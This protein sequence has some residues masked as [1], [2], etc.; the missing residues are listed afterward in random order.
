MAQEGD[1]VIDVTDVTEVITDLTRVLMRMMK[2]GRRGEGG[3][4]MKIIR[5]GMM[6]TTAAA[7][8]DGGKIRV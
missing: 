1:D 2:E 5:G 7:D 4:R 6:K 3:R 8:S